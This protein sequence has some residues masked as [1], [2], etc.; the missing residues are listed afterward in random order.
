ME[1]KTENR[2]SQ[3]RLYVVAF[4]HSSITIVPSA[5]SSLS[6]HILHLEGGLKDDWLLILSARTSSTEKTGATPDFLYKQSLEMAICWKRTHGKL[7][8]S[9]LR[10]RK[11]YFHLDYVFMWGDLG[12]RG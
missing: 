5:K 7:L 1:K 9:W 4:I 11:A 12:R 3:G 6:G 10:I 2:K 8:R